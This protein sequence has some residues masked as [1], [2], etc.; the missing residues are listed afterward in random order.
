[1]S[2]RNESQKQFGSYDNKQTHVRAQKAVRMPSVLLAL[3]LLKRENRLE[4]DY[5]LDLF[6]IVAVP[7]FNMGAVENKSLTIFNSKLV[8]ASPETATDADYASILGVIGHEVYHLS[9][10]KQET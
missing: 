5:D 9:H 3:L 2:A 8:L 6:N 7:D 4:T 10:K 1:M